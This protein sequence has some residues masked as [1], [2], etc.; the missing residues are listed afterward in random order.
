MVNLIWAG[1]WVKTALGEY[2]GKLLSLFVT[3][4]GNRRFS[5]KV[6]MS[7]VVEWHR[8]G[9]ERLK[10]TLLHLRQNRN[11]VVDEVTFWWLSRQNKWRPPEELKG[12]FDLIKDAKDDILRISHKEE[13]HTFMIGDESLLPAEIVDMM[14]DI[15]EK[16]Q[17]FNSTFRCALA[18]GYDMEWEIN[19]Q[20]DMLF[21]NWFQWSQQLLR[22]A[23]SEKAHKWLREPDIM[24][25]AGSDGRHRTSGGFMWPNTA[26]H[27][28]RAHWPTISSR[29]IDFALYSGI[30]EQI[31]NGK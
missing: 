23:A 31:N 2:N 5:R 21:P 16:T 13:V 19:R 15:S 10:D 7:H 29:H 9:V 17:Q 26:L 3:P 30:M 22:H 28:F 20:A 6:G 11:N 4:D 27:F 24:I 12:L 25:R 18:L 14:S 8:E 1:P